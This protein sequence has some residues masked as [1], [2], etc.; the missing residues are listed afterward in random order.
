MKDEYEISICDLSGALALPLISELFA[1]YQSVEALNIL[2][3]ML[4]IL[5][6]NGC[7][8]RVF[9]SIH[10]LFKTSGI[11][12]PQEFY[13]IIITEKD[14]C[15]FAGEFLADFGEILSELSG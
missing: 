3:Q 13:D 10:T 6:N 9:D 12:L 14:K 15:D 7:G 11:A 2:L 1:E 8:I 5:F 4:T